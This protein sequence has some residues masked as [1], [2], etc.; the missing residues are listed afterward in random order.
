[1]RKKIRDFLQ[2]ESASGI[3]LLIA[4]ALA[5]LAANSVFSPIYH[6][7]SERMQFFV[8]EG[9]MAV[10]FLMVGLELKRG[11]IED[12]HARAADILLPLAAAAGGMA[13]PALI[14]LLFNFHDPVTV[15]G[16]ATPVATDIAFAIGV[17]SLFGKHISPAL[18]LFLL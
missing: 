16:F 13:V 8:N 15:H 17:V 12:Q 9:L 4:A 1:M 18:K 14:Y 10:F 5:M 7:I 6:Q 2:L 3:I 11:F